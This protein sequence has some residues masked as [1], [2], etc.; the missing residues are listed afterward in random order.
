MDMWDNKDIS[1]KEILDLESLGNSQYPSIV[2]NKDTSIDY[3]NP[4]FERMTGFKLQEIRGSK[5]PYP[6]WA[7]STHEQYLDE[8]R[9]FMHQSAYLGAKLFLAKNKERLW[10]E[11]TGRTVEKKGA[12]VKYLE[13]W[14]SIAEIDNTEDEQKIMEQARQTLISI[15]KDRGDFGRIK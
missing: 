8:L 10:V 4:A 3:V 14:K 1:T 5:A 13:S 6:W 7:E 9:N 12:G 11:I 2:I 15:A